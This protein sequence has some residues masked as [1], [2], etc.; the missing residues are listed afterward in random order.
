[1]VDT[2]YDIKCD[3]NAYHDGRG[4]RRFERTIEGVRTALGPRKVLLKRNYKNYYI[5][6]RLPSTLE[7]ICISLIIMS[8]TKFMSQIAIDRGWSF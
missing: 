8:C 2:V 7:F 5:F 6:I 1:M 3:T 4:R